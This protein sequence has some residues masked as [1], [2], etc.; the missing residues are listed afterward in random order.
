MSVLTLELPDKLF[1]SLR[2]QAQKANTTVEHLAISTLDKQAKINQLRTE[3]QE[4]VDAIKEGRFTRYANADEMMDDIERQ[5]KER[6]VA[7]QSNGKQ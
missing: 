5:I 3:V 6:I 1:K 4:G 2:E 7:K